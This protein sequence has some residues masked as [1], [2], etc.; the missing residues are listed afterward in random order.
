[1]LATLIVPVFGMKMRVTPSTVRPR[2]DTAAWREMPFALF[3]CAVFLGFLGL[4]IPF[5]YVQLYSI[6]HAIV[7]T[8]LVF[9][10]VPLLNAGSLFGRV[11]SNF[12]L[13]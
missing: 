12:Y 13:T 7:D 11:V 4:Y 2:F 3:A 1:M 9:Y 6:E 10:L 5:F 8:S